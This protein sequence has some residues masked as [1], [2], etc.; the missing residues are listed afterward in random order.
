MPL[1]ALCEHS[2]LSPESPLYTLHLL[3]TAEPLPSK[4]AVTGF[5]GK[6][7]Q[8]RFITS[9][10]GTLEGACVGLGDNTDPWALAGAID[11]L[12]E[13]VWQ[14]AA[15][16][17]GCDANFVALTWA[18]GIYR[19]TRYRSAPTDARARLLWPQNADRPLV[20]RTIEAVERV[21]DMVNTPAEDMGPDHI[22][23]LVRDLAAH[24]GAQVDV[25]TGPDLLEKGYPAIHAVGR[26]SHRP[27]RLIDLRWGDKN[28][29]KVTLVG[30]GVCFDTG[31]LDLKPSSGMRLMKKDMGGAAHAFALAGM[32]MDAALPVC[33]RLLI[34]AVDNAV[35]GNAMRPGDILQTRK[36]LTVEVSN[37]DAEGRLILAD[38]LA[39]GD[40]EAPDLMIDFATLTGAARV[41]LGPEL[42]ALFCRDAA[43][44]NTLVT[45]GH[46]THD[47][48]WSLPLWKGYR[49]QLDS[50]VADLD[51]APEGGMAGAILAALFL[52]EF[53]SDTTPWVHLDVYAWNQKPRI[54]RPVGGE[55]MALRAIFSYLCDRFS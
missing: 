6:I 33:L 8:V 4:I 12:P 29:P 40:R 52:A 15:L 35:A 44:A 34:P 37:T 42:P 32:I 36:G 39:E 3:T 21:R 31:G 47:P 7:G 38:A 19:F 27:P 9:V 13:G 11:A 46:N 5:N 54:G 24:T 43:L 2:A 49:A 16:P 17:K 51:N 10:T 50:P 20:T 53:V 18:L 28:A 55:A 26:A 25:I 48:V 45:A 30:K 1:T 23:G 41:A 14:I 22:E